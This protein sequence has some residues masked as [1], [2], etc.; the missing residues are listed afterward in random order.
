MTTTEEKSLEKVF[1][2]LCGVGV[3]GGTPEKKIKGGMEVIKCFNGKDIAR[4]LKSL[5]MRLKKSE[6]DLMI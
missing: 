4:V 1:G 5:G 2:L 3:A 6:I